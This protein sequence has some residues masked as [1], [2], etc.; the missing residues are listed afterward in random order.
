MALEKVTKIDKVE[1][2]EDG[3]IQTRTAEV[4]L[5]DGVELNRRYVNRQVFRPGESVVGQSELVKDIAALVHTDQVI[6][7][8]E[9]RVEEVRVRDLDV[10]R[11][12]ED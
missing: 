9:A 7:A 6:E 2:L 8:H 4:I 12:E 10:N 5:E 11:G 3:T 1:I